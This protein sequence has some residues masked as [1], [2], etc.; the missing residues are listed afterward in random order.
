M[1]KYITIIF[2]VSITDLFSQDVELTLDQC[3]DLAIENNENLKNAKL[4]E[5]ISKALS[6]EYLSVGLPQINFD[7][8][9]KYNHDVP[10][11]L[12]D[13]S[14]FMPGVPEGTE[15]EVSFGQDYDGRVDLFINQMIFNNLL[16]IK[17][18]MI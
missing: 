11:S 1:K 10:K 7:G 15:Q 8:G 3:I 16:K 14:R 9:L 4:E 13:I 18:C 12:I 5:K 17:A 2:I 6:R